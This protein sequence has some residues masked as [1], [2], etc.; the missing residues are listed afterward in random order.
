[1]FYT[2]SKALGAGAQWEWAIQVF[3]TSL[4]PDYG[5][6]HCLLFII[7]FVKLAAAL[8]SVCT[9]AQGMTQGGWRG[10]QLVMIFDTLSY[11]DS[12]YT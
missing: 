12:T 11:F 3:D 6:F 10:I 8:V 1:M 4:L 5:Y 9:G 2:A 7:G